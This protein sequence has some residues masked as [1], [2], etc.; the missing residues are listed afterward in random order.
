MRSFQKLIGVGIAAIY[1]PAPSGC[2]YPP[3]C[4]ES[5]EDKYFVDPETDVY[6]LHSDDYCLASEVLVSCSPIWCTGVE[7]TEYY[8]VDSASLRAWADE[9]GYVLMHT[10]DANPSRLAPRCDS[11]PD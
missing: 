3:D 9:Q 11:T 2:E 10:D 5:E 7:E 6:D 8:C 4:P 1:L